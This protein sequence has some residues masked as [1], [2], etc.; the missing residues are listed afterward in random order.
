MEITEQ[1]KLRD[2]LDENPWLPEALKMEDVRA[3]P[4]IAMMNSPLG[5]NALKTATVADAARYLNRPAQR[6][7]DELNRVLIS[8]G[9]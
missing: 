7:I 4:F 5:K 6:L 2:I 1:T 3:R 8:H 9:A